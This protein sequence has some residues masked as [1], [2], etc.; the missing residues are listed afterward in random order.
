MKKFSYA[1]LWVKRPGT[2]RIKASQFNKILNKKAS[3][4]IKKDTH[5]KLED[6]KKMKKKSFNYYWRLRVYR[7][8]MLP[9]NLQKKYKV[10]I[11]D[12]NHPKNMYR[13]TKFVKV[14]NRDISL[15]LLVLKEIKKQ[16]YLLFCR[17]C[18]Y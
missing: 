13:K 1:N 4:N 6:I 10:T 15:I 9:R 16:Y 7:E 17:Y 2:G 3:R 8:V 11:V 5:L 12:I 18:R 14:T